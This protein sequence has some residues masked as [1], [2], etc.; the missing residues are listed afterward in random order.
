MAAA[1]K[2]KSRYW[3]LSCPPGGG[4]TAAT[5]QTLQWPEGLRYAVWALRADSSLVAYVEWPYTATAPRLLGA[6]HVDAV[7]VSGSRD[8]QRR[9][10]IEEG[11]GARHWET[12]EW[13]PDGRSCR[14]RACRVSAAD[15]GALEVP[16]Q[17]AAPQDQDRVK[18][19][20]QSIPQK[21]LRVLKAQIIDMM[22]A[23]DE[24]HQA[25]IRERDAEMRELKRELEAMRCQQLQLQHQRGSGG[26]VNILITINNFGSEDTSFL[27]AATRR[28]RFMARSPGLIETVRDVHLN[29]QR[30]E[31]RNVRIQ[32]RKRQL[33]ERFMDGQW[34]VEP[35]S[36]L[37]DA[38]LYNGFRIN[39]APYYTDPAFQKEVDDGPYSGM[40]QE[41]MADVA[42]LGSRA[43]TSE[44]KKK[45]VSTARQ[46]SCSGT[47]P[48]T[49]AVGEPSERCGPCP[50]SIA[51]W[52][53]QLEPAHRT[54]NRQAP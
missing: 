29:A 13:V 3:L 34:V 35:L 36:R 38:M 27:S 54:K 44:I 10:V 8:E 12:G 30:P 37:V 33:A 5:A 40:I 24:Q 39:S 19:A 18:T 15:T 50:P 7:V 25:E 23:R 52:S 28:E 1:A 4:L 21:E 26:N 16:Q 53:P 42:V 31:N 17:S 45:H 41:W 22:R 46:K 43:A 6:R 11:G 2:V 47:I 9:R 49:A 48:M 32:S 14:G 51:C 20:F